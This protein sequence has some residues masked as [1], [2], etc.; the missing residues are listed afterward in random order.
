MSGGEIVVRPHAGSPP[1]DVIAGNTVLYG[2]TGGRL[3][4]A[5]RAGERFA[6]R[7]SGALAVVEGV[8]DHACEYM[9]AG[10]VVIL[11]PWGE[12]LAAGM[13]G[14]VTFVLDRENVLAG[15]HN[16][17][18]VLVG[19]V[20]GEDQAWLLEVVELHARATGSRGAEAL[21]GS[22]D[23]SLFKTLVP[24]GSGERRLPRLSLAAAPSPAETS[25]GIVWSGAIS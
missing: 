4:M 24:R 21:L 13:T 5:G 17:E 11:G 23:P 14:G 9:T 1:D 22:W 8:G 18:L 20:L 7:N 25:E 19:D 10:A 16:T 15:R 6:V 12:N 3:F 2:A